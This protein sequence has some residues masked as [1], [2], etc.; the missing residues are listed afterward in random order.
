M[1][2]EV[3]GKRLTPHGATAGKVRIEGDDQQP[4]W[5]P[6]GEIAAVLRTAGDIA[7]DNGAHPLGG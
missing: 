3:E 7:A 5:V 4:V 2:V 6:S 1:V